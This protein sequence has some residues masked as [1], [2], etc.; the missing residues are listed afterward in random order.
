MGEETIPSGPA[1]HQAAAPRVE[2]QSHTQHPS[3]M[4]SLP[5]TA[6]SWQE[7]PKGAQQPEGLL[8]T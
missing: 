7:C 1:G 2:A 3:A 8:G 6:R 4:S 5:Q